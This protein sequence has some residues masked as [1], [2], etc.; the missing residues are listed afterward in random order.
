MHSQETRKTRFKG[1]KKRL[2]PKGNQLSNGWKAQRREG[3]LLPQ[4][5][6]LQPGEDRSRLTSLHLLAVLRHIIW[7]NGAQEFNIVIAVVLGHLL[8][9]G[10]VRALEGRRKKG[11]VTLEGSQPV[12]AQSSFNT[13]SQH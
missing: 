10:F 6:E 3:G 2:T 11:Q 13:Q 4:E 12:L 1:K 9:I 7:T 8:S 5:G